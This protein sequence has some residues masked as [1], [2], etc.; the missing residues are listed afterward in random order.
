MYNKTENLIRS[1]PFWKNEIKIKAIKGGLTNQNFL[2]QE[3]SKKFF[4]RL[5]D[6]MPE[7]NVSR[8]KELIASNAAAEIGLS[9]AVIYNTKGV[10]VLEYIEGAMLSTDS[11]VDKL[12]SII[13]LIRKIHSEMSKKLYG[14]SVNFGAFDA[15]KRY[16][17]LLK[18]HKSSYTQ[19]LP[20]LLF[21]VDKLEINTSPYDIV[22]CHNDLIFTNF[23]DDEDRL[24][25][26]DWEYSGFNN[27]LFD[28]G[29]FASHCNFPENKEIFLL[30]NYFEK[31]INEKLLLEFNSF[32]CAAILREAMWSMVAELT[33]KIDFNFLIYTQEKLAKFNDAYNKL[34]LK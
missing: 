23:L 34:S 27:P 32:K 1:L 10:L 16:A 17:K 25:I 2:V 29:D 20:S 9:P 22:F 15:I 6:D 31:K 5:G 26:V 21:Q 3:N 28:L 14:H 8:S 7:H 18:N 30:E 24:W 11:I 33:S 4:V 12:E 19:L 13:S